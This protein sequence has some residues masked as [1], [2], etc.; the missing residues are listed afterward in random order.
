[1]GQKKPLE[2]ADVYGQALKLNGG[3]SKK[4][5]LTAYNMLTNVTSSVR[6]GKATEAEKARDQEIMGKLASLRPSDSKLSGEKMGPWYHMFGI[7]VAAQYGVGGFA[8]FMSAN[9]PGG[10]P[11]KKSID[12]LAR[13]SF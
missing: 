7:G 10:D 9:G 8:A 6:G 4:A 12:G 3:D 5:A 2:P 13:D 11:E 1:V